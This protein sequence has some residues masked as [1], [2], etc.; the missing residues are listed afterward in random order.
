M[1]NDTKKLNPKQAEAAHHPGGPILIAAGAGSGK[2]HTLI[3]RIKYLLD[4]LRVPPSRILAIT[5]TN[6]AALEMQRRI[7]SPPELFIGTFHSFGARLLRREAQRAGRTD[8]FTIFDNDDSFSLLKQVLRAM[9][10]S[11]ETYNPPAMHALIGTVKNECALP[12]HAA[13]NNAKIDPAAFTALFNEY[14]QALK[15]NNAFDFDD[16]IEKP[17]RLLRAEDDVRQKYAA[18]YDHILID[19]YQD[20][21]NAQYE[22]VRLLAGTHNNISVVGDDAQSIYKFRGADFRNFL[23]FERDWPNAKIV[24]LEEN[25]RSTPTILEA[26][27]SII[28][29]NVFQKQK[30]LWTGNPEGE[31]IRVYAA[32]NE[33]D[34]AEWIV[35]SAVAR[36]RAGIALENMAII[37]RTNAQ[38]RALEQTLIA[39]GIPYRIFGGIRFYERK[40][41]KDIVAGLR[42]AENPQDTVSAERIAKNFSQAKSR[43]ILDHMPRLAAE[44][45]V[46]QL[47]D[48]FLD[49][50]EYLEYLNNNYKNAEERLENI[51][52]LISFAEP[53][54][55]KGLSAFLEQITL[56]QSHDAPQGKTGVNLMTIHLSKGL[57]FET[58]FIAGA[59]EGILPHHRSY[60][61]PEE[62][63]EERRLM[64][65]A[66]TRAGRELAISFSNIPS[67]FLYEIPGNIIDFVNVKNKEGRG[68]PLPDEEELWLDYE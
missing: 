67:R 4:D 38:S 43:R 47:I 32:Q 18:R 2:T 50:T 59:S 46:I 25:Y 13:L 35:K 63:E 41:I 27:N 62:L 28:K 5:F 51:Q 34:E 12:E 49:S 65:V 64:Y 6:K 54:G 39:A 11:K 15:N 29:N 10:L 16:L 19:E 30:N 7:A 20:I 23:N 24:L 31:R 60:G 58:V 44:L 17:V 48:Y 3:S 45:T 8:R 66:V 53:F 52:G 26:A 22:L 61:T 37:Y 14:E 56:M 40:E 42:F 68:Q 57:E 21:N 1:F 36:M 9:N 33:N 55:N